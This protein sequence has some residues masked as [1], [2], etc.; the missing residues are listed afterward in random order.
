MGF[1]WL[2][3]K[4]NVIFSQFQSGIISRVPPPCNI[5]SGTLGLVAGSEKYVYYIYRGA[6]PA[7][8]PRWD[9]PGFEVGYLGTKWA[10]AGSGQIMRVPYGFYMG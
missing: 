3:L 6:L 5:M 7:S 2:N 8:T 4:Y 10:W 9:P 1:K